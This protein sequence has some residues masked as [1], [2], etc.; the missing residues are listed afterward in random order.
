[1]TH[2]NADFLSKTRWFEQRQFSEKWAKRNQLLLQLIKTAKLDHQQLNFS[3]YGCGPHQ[4]FRQALTELGF[5][6]VVHSLDMNQWHD[7]VIQIDL[8][9]ADFDRVPQADVGVLSGVLE[10]LHRPEKVLTGLAAKH[11]F[12]L[13]SYRVFE[14]QPHGAMEKYTAEINARAANGWKTH[15]ILPELLK[16]V[17]NFGFIL[18]A[19]SWRNQCLFLL[20]KH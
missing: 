17:D 3:E 6:G 16:V 5:S 2:K 18:A 10:Y 9:S 11:D 19:E 14:Y 12:L 20:K 7:N 13:V 15:L 4:S 1:M 8:E